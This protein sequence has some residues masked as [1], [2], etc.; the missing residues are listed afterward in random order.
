MVVFLFLLFFRLFE[1]LFFLKVLL[2]VVLRPKKTLPHFYHTHH[3]D[4]FDSSF[5]PAFQKS[6]HSLP[7]QP[8][9]TT[10][11]PAP[12]SRHVH[13]HSQEKKQSK[14]RVRMKAIPRS[15]VTT[16]ALTAL[17]PE[18]VLDVMV[19]ELD[20]LRSNPPSCD[21]ATPEHS[22]RRRGQNSTFKRRH[23]KRTRT[24]TLTTP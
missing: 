20:E 17:F 11:A 23:Q 14:R 18:I 3:D 21:A 12:G 10:P 4:G 19:A 24:P 7:F 15:N 2:V 16:L 9:H 1:N 8:H 13:M 6:T 22:T 5:S